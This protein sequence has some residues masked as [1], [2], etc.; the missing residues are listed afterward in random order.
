MTPLQYAEK[1]AYSTK[2]TLLFTYKCAIDCRYL[3][4]AYVECGVAAGAQVI[5]MAY[6]APNKSIYCF[7]SFE[8]I[9]LASNRD[10]ERPGIKG[11]KESER[12]TLPDPGEEC[13]LISSGVTS[14]PEDDFKR[15]LIEANVMRENIYTIKG[16]FEETL[17]KNDIKEISLLR[18]DGDL[19][20]STYVCLKHLFE[21]VVRGGIIIIDDWQLRGC[22]E[23]CEDYFRTVN[24]PPNY[25]TISNIAYFVK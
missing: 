15:H 7:D 12:I 1:I 3:D 25:Q 14:V 19:Y 22:R 5:A 11:I 16:W 24:Y 23:A 8:G 20:N 18:L 2:E 9:P 10:Y 17:P 6:G 4:G 21:K 13:L